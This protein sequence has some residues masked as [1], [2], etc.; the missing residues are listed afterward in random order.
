MTQT[1]FQ[2]QAQGASQCDVILRELEAHRGQWVSALQ[3]HIRS[4]SLAV[5]SRIAD[6]RARGHTI[7]QHSGR[8][9]RQVRSS[10]QLV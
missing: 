1:E 8:A 3:L 10:Y 5:H 2:L 6:L 9:G 7:L 4:G